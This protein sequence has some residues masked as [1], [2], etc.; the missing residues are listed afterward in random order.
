VFVILLA[1][2]TLEVV[3]RRGHRDRH[4]RH[5]RGCVRP[6]TKHRSRRASACS[7]TGGKGASFLATN[8]KNAML[9]VV[10]MFDLHSDWFQQNNAGLLENGIAADNLCTNMVSQNIFVTGT[11]GAK[12]FLFLNNAFHNKILSGPYN[13]YLFL[14]SQLNY[15]HSHVVLAHNSMASQGLAVRTDTSYQPDI[16]CL[17]A[18]NA[19]MNLQWSG[20]ANATLKIR[21]N[22]LSRGATAPAG[23]VSTVIGGTQEQSFTSSQQGLFGPRGVL[24]TTVMAPCMTYDRKGR[25][26]DYIDSAGSD[27]IDRP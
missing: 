23:G 4:L 14:Q 26:R 9:T 7:L 12:D 11:A 15:R 1:V 5:A 21:F 18:N 10:T 6:D 16:Y 8:V 19:L 2:I 20:A 13:N 3:R 27:A 22:Y 24:R 25:R 17:V